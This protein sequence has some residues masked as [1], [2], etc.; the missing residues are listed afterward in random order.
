MSRDEDKAFLIEQLEALRQQEAETLA[1]MHEISGAQKMVRF[2]LTKR[3]QM[4]QEQ[5]AGEPSPESGDER[6]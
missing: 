2:L 6:L 1:K 3:E 4:A 5:T